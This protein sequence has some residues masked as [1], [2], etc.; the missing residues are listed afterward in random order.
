[1]LLLGFLSLPISGH[2][3]TDASKFDAES[4]A[5]K[6]PKQIGNF[7]L[8]RTWYEQAGGVPAVQAAAYSSPGSDEIILGVW[9]AAL[10][11]VHDPEACWLARGLEPQLITMRP[12][13]VEGGGSE[14]LNTGFYGDG[15][16]DSIVVNALCT[17]ETCSQYQGSSSSRRVGFIILDQMS[18]LTRSNDHP[19]S[20]MIRID[21]LHGNESKA[22]TQDV[23]LKE[24]EQFIAGL[25]PSDLSRAFQ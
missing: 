22:T 20:I 12:F 16:T 18:A 17:P 8:K 4:F 21:R 24:A 5:A 15:I 10:S 13:R 3:A 11:H 1:V 25:N 14:Q 6:M 19:V 23:L 9:V 7:T 2:S